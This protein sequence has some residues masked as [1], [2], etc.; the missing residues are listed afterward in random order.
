MKGEEG[1]PGPEESSASSGLG[2]IDGKAFASEGHGRGR[3][4]E[5]TQFLFALKRKGGGD[6]KDSGH[7]N[8]G[9]ALRIGIT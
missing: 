7:C 2:S 5:V 9:Q 3:R 8:I 1:E 4:K 6:W